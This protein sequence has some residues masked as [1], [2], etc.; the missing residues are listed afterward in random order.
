MSQTMMSIQIDDQD[1]RDF[2]V[3]C[4]QMGMSAS[5]VVGAFMRTALRE[6]RLPF[7]EAEDPFYSEA[8]MAR[9]R[10]AVAD[11]NAGKGVEHELIEVDDD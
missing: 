2:E 5:S 1:R 9:L 8:N 10:R 11:L 3:L 4:A 7:V 6:R